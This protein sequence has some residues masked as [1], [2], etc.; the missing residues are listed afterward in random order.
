MCRVLWAKSRAVDG[1]SLK[2]VDEVRAPNSFWCDKNCNVMFIIDNIASKNLKSFE[3][4][5][6]YIFF[7]RVKIIIKLNWMRI[8]NDI[9]IVPVNS[10]SVYHIAL[11]H[12]VQTTWLHHITLRQCDH[13]ITS[14]SANVI[15]SHQ[16]RQRD[17]TTS[18][19]TTWVR[20]HFTFNESQRKRKTIS[21]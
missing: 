11:S 2:C 17:H 15:T 7:R 4:L 5:Q 14:H 3:Y 13:I 21:C 10:W 19:A 1:I 20:I 16:G 8:Y 9:R 12:H 6:Y 18:C